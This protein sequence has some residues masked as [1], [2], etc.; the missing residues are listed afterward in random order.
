MN[1]FGNAFYHFTGR[2]FS[3][4]SDIHDDTANIRLCDDQF[5]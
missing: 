2:G 3:I 4:T 5:F 1:S